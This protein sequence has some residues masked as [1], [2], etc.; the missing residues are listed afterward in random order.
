VKSGY[1]GYVPGVKSENCYGK[2]YGKTSLSSAAGELN[3]GL[4]LPIAVKFNTTSGESMIDHSKTTHKTTAQIVGVERSE[5]C[6]TRVS[7]M[8]LTE[9]LKPETDKIFK[10]AFIII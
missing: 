3:R 6:Y 1:G 10:H 4:D 9:F 2:T 5:D 8:K 7:I